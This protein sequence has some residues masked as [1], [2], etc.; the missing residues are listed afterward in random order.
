MKIQKNVSLKNHTT[1]RVGGRA[2][3]F[4]ETESKEELIEAIKAAKEKNLPFFIL[5]QG[6]NVLAHDNGFRGVVIKIKN[7]KTKIEKHNLKFKVFCEAGTPLSKMVFESLKAG[8][9]G[10]EWAAGIPGT[11]GGAVYGN[12]GAF[13]FSMADSVENVTAL[14]S[15][16]LTIKKIEKKDCLF[17]CKESVFKKKKNLIILGATLKLNKGEKKAISKRIEKNTKEKRDNQPLNFPSAGCIFTNPRKIVR[18]KK[19][20]KEFPEIIKF[21]QKGILPAG[22]L[23]DKCGL[24]GKKIG[25]AGISPKHANFIVNLG[26]AKSKD[27]EKLI[28]AIK[29]A[30]EKKFRI[31]LAEEI[32]RIK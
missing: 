9:T 15:I 28:S 23:I 22:W 29:K 4:I 19:L 1:F 14:D 11:I 32:Q 6:S 30:V 20:L 18:N 5:G 21:N 12:A 25:G 24:K 10:M 3:Y 31:K 17:G 27:I 7:S 2:L 16:N 26:G 13:G 8:A